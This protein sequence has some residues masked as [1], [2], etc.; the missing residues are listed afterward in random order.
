MPSSKQIQQK[1]TVWV[2]VC[3]KYPTNKQTIQISP[4]ENLAVEQRTLQRS[5]IWLAFH[6][7]PILLVKT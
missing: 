5:A 4:Q 7:F 3:C 1:K 2:L 6:A